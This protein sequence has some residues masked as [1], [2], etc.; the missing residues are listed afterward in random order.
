MDNN[1][2]LAIIEKQDWL[3]PVETTL[4]KAVGTA[5]ES[6]GA[7]GRPIRNA[8]NGVWLGHP[9]HPVL[10]DIPIGAWSTAVLLDAADGSATA[11]GYTQAADM[12]IAFGLAGALGSAVTGL[13]DWADT[14]GSSRR[15]GLIH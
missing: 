4:Q 6:A 3:E 15:I 9:L 13:T 1:T 2:S 7:A 12:A 8:L 10:T 11:N 5:F 14:D